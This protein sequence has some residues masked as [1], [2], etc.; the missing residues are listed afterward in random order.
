MAELETVL[1][2]ETRAADAAAG[3]KAELRLWLRLLTCTTMIEGEVRRRLRERFDT[4]LPRFDLLAQLERAPDGLTL[5]EISRRMMVSNGNVT[6]LAERLETEGLIERR[7][8]AS[9]RRASYLRLTATGRAEF[10]RMAREHEGWIADLFAG[11]A[12]A[13]VA[14]LMALLGRAK[15]SVRAATVPEGGR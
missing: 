15:E 1:D 12:A 5:G 14:A 6:G 10:A 7:R 4:T 9:D 11:L 13:D 3:H 8:S 2:S